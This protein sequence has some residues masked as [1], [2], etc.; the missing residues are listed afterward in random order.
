M[1][2]RGLLRIDISDLAILLGW[3]DHKVADTKLDGQILILKLDGPD[4][5]IVP[6]GAVIPDVES[7]VCDSRQ[8]A[9]KYN[10]KLLAVRAILDDEED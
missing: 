7:R 6:E 8:Q 1:K 5:P 3:P 4:C 10:R 2:Q 9:I